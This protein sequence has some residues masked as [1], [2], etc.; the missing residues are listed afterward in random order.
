MKQ[1]FIISTLFL[2]QSCSALPQENNDLKISTGFYA[3]STPKKINVEYS[4]ISLPKKISYTLER[5][6]DDGNFKITT[7]QIYGCNNTNYEIDKIQLNK[8]SDTFFGIKSTNRNI[9]SKAC[10]I[11]DIEIDIMTRIKSANNNDKSTKLAHN[12]FYFKDGRFE[13]NSK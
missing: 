1:I 2:I 5:D 10:N 4:N 13:I 6:D 8:I 11:N 7:L 12:F 9:N 3:I